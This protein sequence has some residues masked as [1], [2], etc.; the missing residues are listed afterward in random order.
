MV[1]GIAASALEEFPQPQVLRVVAESL[2][3]HGPSDELAYFASYHRGW[4]NEDQ[5]KIVHATIPYLQPQSSTLPVQR[6]LPP[7]APTQASGAIKLLRFIFYVPNHAWPENPELESYADAQ[8][9][10]AAPNIMAHANV[11]AVQELALYLG[12]MRFSSREHELLLQIAERSD[13]AGEQA[14]IALTWHPQLR[15]LC[16]QFLLLDN[17]MYLADVKRVYAKTHSSQLRFAIEE[18]FL[19]VSDSL[20]EGLNPSGGPVTSII[21]QA[22]PESC[23]RPSPG[24]TAFVMKYSQRQDFH[25]T[26]MVTRWQYVLTNSTTHQRIA[27]VTV[28]QIGGWSPHA[29]PIVR[30]GGS[31]RWILPRIADV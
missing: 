31:S 6:Q 10:Q 19:K 20:Y 22:S 18:E 4:T 8:V 15:S 24:N 2:E 30:R 28:R 16:L 1:S 9:L 17:A 29:A 3:E 14:R 7:Y 5:N 25:D 21:I 27:P 13:G 26:G 23:V 12:A 11:N